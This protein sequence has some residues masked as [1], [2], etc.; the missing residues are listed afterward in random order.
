MLHA[1]LRTF[2]LC[3]AGAALLSAS[4]DD[5]DG[6]GGGGGGTTTTL[7]GATTTSVAAASTTTT[8]L[9]G[10]SRACVVTWRVGNA[11]TI[12]ALQFE[13]LYGSAPGN[14]SGSDDSVECDD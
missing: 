4:C 14:L 8:T 11:A 10:C 5:S 3:L 1:K 13:T 12:G 2:V 6:N 9:D 7:T